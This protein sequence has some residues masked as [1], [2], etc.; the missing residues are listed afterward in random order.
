MT[1]KTL[2]AI[3]IA[4]ILLVT[5]ALAGMLATQGWSSQARGKVAVEAVEHMRLLLRLQAQLRLERVTTNLAL[6]KP[7]PS[8]QVQ[9]R[10]GETRRDTDQGIDDI[11]ARLRENDDFKINNVYRPEPYL[12]NVTAGLIEVRAAIDTV[13]ANGQSTPNFSTLNAMMPRM[14]AVAQGLDAPLEHAS[15]AVTAADP[16]LSGLLTEDRLAASLRDQIGLIASLLLPRYSTGQKPTAAD[17]EQ[18]PIL[19]ARAAYLT[20][21]IGDTIEVAGA[22]EHIRT[23]LAAL[24]AIDLTATPGRLR[25][26]TDAPRPVD[27]AGE[28]PLQ[29][30]LVPWGELINGLRNAIV[31]AAMGRVTVRRADREFRFNLVLTAFG[32]VLFAVLES[33]VLLSQRVV[34]PL[35]QLGVAITRIAAGDRGVPLK[36]QTGT[37]EISEMVTA[38]ETLRQ[39]ALVAD[40][41][42]LRRRMTIR[43]RL[44]MLREAM[45]IARTVQAPAHALERGVAGLSEGIDAT[46]A[47]ITAAKTATPSTLETAADA[48]RIGLAEMRETAADF[49]ASFA[50]ARSAQTEDRPEAEYMAHIRAV[51]TEVERRDQAVRGFV[52]PSLVAL[53]D[54]TA[55]AACGPD[56]GKHGAALRELVSDQFER[57]EETVAI[58]AS[59][60]DAVTRAAA[61]VRNLVPDDTPM[62]A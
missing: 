40:A 5:L 58:M 41:T 10:L 24:D 54:A 21:L 16:S 17:M 3:P 1:L 26:A 7:F 62:A 27:D 38:V 59:M 4:V 42:S 60:R 31:E 12:R 47:M 46:I 61:I 36:M 57:I 25:A 52:L 48:I 55:A 19:L 33:I 15:L 34:T 30:V 2:F 9:Q 6:G 13:L 49:D 35:A 56:A 39:A 14:I 43:H 50:A 53:R 32:G 45:G 51:Q 44:E 23:S 22:T 28:L 29:L 37:R 8:E 11:Y 20:R 18:L